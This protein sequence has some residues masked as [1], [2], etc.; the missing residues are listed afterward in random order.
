MTVPH[1]PEGSTF[2]PKGLSARDVQDIH[3]QAD[4]D[5]NVFAFHHTLGLGPNQASSGSHTHDGRNSKKL[6]GYVASDAPIVVTGS[7]GGNAALASLLT[8]LATK[9]IITDGTTA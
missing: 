4:V 7:R 6:T 8:A 9:G 2:N 1:N 5:A 3:R